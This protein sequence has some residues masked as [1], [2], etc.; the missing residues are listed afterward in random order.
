MNKK[1]VTNKPMVSRTKTI[2]SLGF[3]ILPF[4]AMI[5]IY[6]TPLF[7]QYYHTAL[8]S[9]ITPSKIQIFY[10]LYIQSAED[11][12]RVRNIVQEQFQHINPLVHDTSVHITSIG[13]PLS[14]IPYEQS[15]SAHHNE[16]SELLTLH[17][18]WEYCQVNNHPEAKVVYLHSKGS[19][20]PHSE[21]DQMRNFLTRSALSNECA[22]LPESCSVCSS[23]MSPLPHPHTSGNMWLARCNYIA[24][25]FDPLQSFDDKIPPSSS[26]EWCRGWGRYLAE[27]WVHS[28]PSVKAC[29]VYPGKDYV[30]NYANIPTG[31]KL[32]ERELEMAPRF[33]FQDYV[34]PGMSGCENE[35]ILLDFVSLRKQNYELL[36]NITKLDDD[37]WGWE[38]L[39]RSLG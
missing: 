18:L 28:H 6:S 19:Y 1:H 4:L 20:H 21:N 8:Q 22:N 13:Y 24:Q 37:W 7:Q 39:K 25:L 10:N 35:G 32:D 36:Y 11:E 3:V 27:H 15:I 23:R 2:S 12:D 33:K 17:A 31:T 38:F 14:S 9:R 29:D 34:L 30:W 16:G 26:P 5:H